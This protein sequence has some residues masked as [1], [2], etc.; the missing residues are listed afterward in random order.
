MV[1]SGGVVG[2]TISN[3]AYSGVSWAGLDVAG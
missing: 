2:G 3:D 1:S